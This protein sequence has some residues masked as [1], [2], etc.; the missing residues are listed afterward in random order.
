MPSLPLHLHRRYRRRFG[1]CR[2]SPVTHIDDRTLHT[3][4]RYPY[5]I[6]SHPHAPLTAHGQ[7]TGASILTRLDDPLLW[8]ETD[9]PKWESDPWTSMPEWVILVTARPWLAVATGGRRD[10]DASS[11]RSCVDERGRNEHGSIRGPSV[12]EPAPYLKIPT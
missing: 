6:H 5:P 2:F 8:S 1:V 9:T 10:R 3:H 4:L 7:R 12:A 11:D